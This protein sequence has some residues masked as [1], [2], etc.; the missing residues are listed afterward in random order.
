M[1]GSGTLPQHRIFQSGPLPHSISFFLSPLGAV[2]FFQHFLIIFV[3]QFDEPGKRLIIALVRLVTVTTNLEVLSD[4]DR[5]YEGLL[6]HIIRQYKK[7]F[8]TM[9]E[10]KHA[11]DKELLTRPER[12]W[13]PNLKRP[14]LCSLNSIPLQ[15]Q[16]VKDLDFS[17]TSTVCTVPYQTI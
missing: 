13:T 9:F 8:K 15:I 6:W 1:E 3:R 5:S 16:F 11:K 17:D 14:N 2:L 12:Q 4:H 7:A 10:G